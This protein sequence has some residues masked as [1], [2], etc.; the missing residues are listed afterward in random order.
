IADDGWKYKDEDN[1]ADSKTDKDR[2]VTVSLEDWA[3]TS[4]LDL[5]NVSFDGHIET[6]SGGDFE[7]RKYD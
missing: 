7:F 3:I 4:T 6:S 1:K 2:L 5:E